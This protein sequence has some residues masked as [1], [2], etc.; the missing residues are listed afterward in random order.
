M[1]ATARDPIMRAMSIPR[2]LL[3]YAPRSRAGRALWLLEES[4]APYELIVH[5]FARSTH[6]EPEYLAVNPDGK[7][8]ALVDRGPGIGAPDWPVV[9]TESSAVCAYIADLVPEAKLA[10]PL[11]SPDRAAYLTWLAYVPAAI[12]PAFADLVFAREKPAPAGAMG[13]PPFAV[14]IQRI[15]SALDPR[16]DDAPYLLGAQFTAADLMVGGM[17]QW[18]KAWGKLPEHASIDRYLATL[19]K[20][21]ALH[22]ARAKEAE[23]L[24]SQGKT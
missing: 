14:V 16:D 2:F 19:E 18:L 6:K 1:P 11:G 8:P 21:P 15:A 5:D 9:V 7:L 12:E 4:G 3:H 10:P 23:V 20:R 17:L 13:W 24:A 22:R